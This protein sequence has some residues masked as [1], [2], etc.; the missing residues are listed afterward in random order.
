MMEFEDST[1]RFL[2]DE[3]EATTILIARTIATEDIHTRNGEARINFQESFLKNE[4]IGLGKEGSIG[5]FR[6]ASSDASAIPLNDMKRRE[7]EPKKTP[8]KKAEEKKRVK[9]CFHDF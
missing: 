2:S 5:K 7:H 4:D 3:A 1:E 8:G 9:F 6:K